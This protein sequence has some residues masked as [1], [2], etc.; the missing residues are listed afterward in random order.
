MR[1]EDEIDVARLIDEGPMSALQIRVVLL[2]SLATFLDGY[3]IQALGLA[4][5]GMAKSFAVA[6]TAFAPALSLTL[7]GIGLGAVVFG[8]LADR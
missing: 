1:E 2:G 8:S 7:L 3:D 6:P 4:I 5:P